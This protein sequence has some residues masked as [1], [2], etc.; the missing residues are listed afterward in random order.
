MKTTLSKHAQKAPVLGDGAMG[1]VNLV[2][3]IL[4]IAMIAVEEP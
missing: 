4:T 3:R 1:V 2:L